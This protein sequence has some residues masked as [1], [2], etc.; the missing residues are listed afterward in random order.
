LSSVGFSLRD[1]DFIQILRR[2]ARPAGRLN[3]LRKKGVSSVGHAFRHDVK[4]MFPSGVLTPEGELVT[5]S[6]ASK[7]YATFIA[8]DI[9]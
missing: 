7:A 2:P 5:F 1:F 6:A 4:A 9:W 8:F 3:S